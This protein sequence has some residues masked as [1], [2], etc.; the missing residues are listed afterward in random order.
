VVRRR[1]LVVAVGFYQGEA[2]NLYLGDELH[3]NGV[4][5]ACGQIGNIHPSVD[6]PAL[7]RRTIDLVRESWLV[8]GGLPR[9]AL[10][11]EEVAQGFE[12][13]GV[14]PRSSRSSWSIETRREHH[15]GRADGP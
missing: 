2:R 5:I 3:H 14:R 9:L 1:G 15:P 13:S 4:R 7:R 12:L 10:R 6:W 8:L 11:V